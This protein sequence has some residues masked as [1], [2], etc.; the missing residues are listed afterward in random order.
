MDREQKDGCAR[1][2]KMH[3]KQ[4]RNTASWEE[5]PERDHNQEVM[6]VNRE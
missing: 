2:L 3:K 4:Q 5:H 1:E 6:E